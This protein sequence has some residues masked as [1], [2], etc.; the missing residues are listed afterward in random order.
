MEGICPEPAGRG[1]T[2]EIFPT[3]DF[4]KQITINHNQ[5]PYLE[6]MCST[7]ACRA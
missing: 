4:E 6:W 2:L 5:M 7:T 3:I 1:R